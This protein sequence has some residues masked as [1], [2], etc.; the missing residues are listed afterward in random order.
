MKPV[1][2]CLIVFICILSSG[3][4]RRTVSVSKPN[5]GSDKTDRQ[6]GR[7]PHS[8]TVEEKTI[9]FWQDEFRNPAK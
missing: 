8:K 5:Q 9:W 1:A 6:S 7:N 2:C 4:V 3:C